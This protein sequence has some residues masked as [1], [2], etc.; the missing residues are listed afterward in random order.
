MVQ[1]PTVLHIDHSASPLTKSGSPAAPVPGVGALS[2]LPCILPP[3]RSS[4]SGRRSVVDVRAGRRPMVI[5]VARARACAVVR[6][7]ARGY[8]LGDARSRERFRVVRVNATVARA[9]TR[10]MPPTA[11]HAAHSA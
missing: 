10:H 4:A 6:A 3:K 7:H 1:N 2:T 11:T 9:P 5:S 8:T